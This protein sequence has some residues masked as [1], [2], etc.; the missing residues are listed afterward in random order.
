MSV[1]RPVFAFFIAGFW[2]LVGIR[3][4]NI[5]NDYKSVAFYSIFLCFH[6]F[7]RERLC[8]SD[9]EQWQVRTDAFAFWHLRVDGVYASFGG[10]LYSIF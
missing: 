8:I 7:F 6:F 9:V 4:F 3:K 5:S 2:H 10:A 1:C